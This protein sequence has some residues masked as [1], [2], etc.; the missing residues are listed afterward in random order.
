MSDP[1]ANPL[2]RVVDHVLRTGF[3]DLPE[4][5]VDRVQTFLLDTLGVGIAG[6][7]GAQVTDLVALAQSW[8]PQPEA[9]VWLTGERMSA[10]SAAIVNAYQIHCLEFDCV[11][12]GAVLHPMA[13]ILSAVLAWVEREAGRGRTVSGRDLIVAMAV[14]LDVSTMLGIVTESELRFFRPATAGGFGAVAAL[15]KLAGFDARQMKDALGA[16]YAQTSGTLQPHVEGSP[17]LGMQVGFNARAAIVAA[18]LA[19]AGFRGPHDILTGKYGYFVLFEQDNY[20]LEPFLARLGQD[21]QALNLSHKPY[22]SGRLTHGAVDALAQLMARD[23]FGPSEVAHIRAEVPPLV[24]RLVGRPDIPQPEANYAKLC[25]RFVAGC[26]LARGRV[27]VPDFRGRE[28]LED[29]EVHRMAALVDVVQDDNPDLNALTPQTF[30]VTLTDGRVCS[31]TL[32]EVYGHP[33]VPLSREENIAKFRRCAGY[34]IRPLPQA[35]T[36]RLIA[37]VDGLADLADATDLVRAATVEGG[38]A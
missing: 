15:G 29:A 31:I 14:G 37:A 27:D 32:D 7:S 9:T 23:G 19:A 20:D 3:E 18:D 1:T 35:Q 38:A 28:A 21:W 12:E 26:Y 36:D 22:P 8:G 5:V 10:Q 11:H 33:D 30:T 4:A 34:G 2:D 24:N 17:M 25:L 16:Q 13:T 6:S